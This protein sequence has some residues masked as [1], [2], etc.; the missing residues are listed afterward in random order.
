[1]WKVCGRIIEGQMC[2]NKKSIIFYIIEI[3]LFIICIGIGFLED[4]FIAPA[5][6]STTV[7]NFIYVF[8]LRRLTGEKFWSSV[9]NIIL[10]WAVG[11]SAIYIVYDT[12][13]F[14]AGYTDY[15]LFGYGPGHTYHGFEAW[16]NNLFTILFAPIALVNII[17]TVIYFVVKKRRK[18]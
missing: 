3:L 10:I 8:L 14:F 2:M 9:S 12:Y 5:F 7:Y 17:Y 11:F 15:G 16:A 4:L 18:K 1:M 6:F 13:I